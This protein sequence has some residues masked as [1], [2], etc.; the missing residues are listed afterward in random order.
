MDLYF[1]FSRR[2]LLLQVRPFFN[3]CIAQVAQENY[4]SSDHIW[5]ADFVQGIDN[6]I[7]I[8]AKFCIY[9]TELSPFSDFGILNINATL[10][11]KYL[12]NILN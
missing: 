4:L 5:H 9:L 12:E 2:D 1:Y 11:T 10:L 6:L 7:K 8:L 3:F